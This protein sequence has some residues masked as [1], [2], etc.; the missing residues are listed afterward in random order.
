[1]ELFTFP[2]W[3]PGKSAIHVV[4]RQDFLFIP[5]VQGTDHDERRECDNDVFIREAP[6]KPHLRNRGPFRRRKGYVPALE[7]TQIAGEWRV[8]QASPFPARYQLL[9]PG[10]FIA[11]HE[12][13][14]NSSRL[15]F[16]TSQVPVT[17]D[18]PRG[19]LMDG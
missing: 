4:D 6:E 14:I 19:K 18:V 15:R 1:M 5:P 8:I 16:G 12:Q 3:P 7:L 9:E 11:V 13:C 17:E 10:Q 2:A